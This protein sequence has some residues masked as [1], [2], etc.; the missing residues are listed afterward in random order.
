VRITVGLPLQDP[1]ATIDDPTTAVRWAVGQNVPFAGRATDAQDGALPASALRWQLTLQHCTSPTN[2]HAHNVQSFDGVS[3]GSFVAPDHEY[4][5]YLDLTLTATDS[6]GNTDST[7]VRLDPRTVD[8]TFTSSPS[9]AQLTVGTVTQAAPFTRTVIVGSNNSISA[10]SP[11][12][13]AL[14][15]RFRF[16]SWSD[17]GAQSHN[18]V[19]PAS[20]T[21][22]RANY[23]LCLFNC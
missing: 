7:T 14:G 19:A 17:G 3:T 6:D 15:L 8:L 20:A 2:C 1:V 11:Q 12:N 5:S 22:Y 4:P 13:L 21:T 18:I 23:Q 10:P 9:G 16:T